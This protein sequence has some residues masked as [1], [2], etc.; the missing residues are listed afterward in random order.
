MCR[1]DFR[2]S[3]CGRLRSQ[4]PDRESDSRHSPSWFFQTLVGRISALPGVEAAS[5]GHVPF[6]PSGTTVV[7]L[8]FRGRPLA[9]VHPAAAVDAVSE[10]FQH[11]SDSAS[12]GTH[13]LRPGRRGL[14]AGG[15][16]R[17]CLRRRLLCRRRCDR[18]FVAKEMRRRKRCTRLWAWSATW[19]SA[20]SGSLHSRRCPCRPCRMD[21]RQHISIV[22]EAPG[23]DVTATVRQQLREM[24]PDVALF[25]VETMADRVSRSVRLRRF[26][27]GLLNIF[28]A[29]GLLIAARR[30]VRNTGSRGPTAAPRNRN[31]AR[32]RE[33]TPPASA[34]ALRFAACWWLGRAPAGHGARNRRGSDDE[35]LPFWNGPARHANG[36]DHAARIRRV[37]RSRFVDSD[38]ARGTDRCAG[39]SS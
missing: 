26:V 39:G 18:K 22:R 25:D 28:A 33:H 16:R 8:H 35:R 13:V 2:R 21:N 5:A 24:D 32:A 27:A 31:Q 29:M 38:G 20:R 1:S 36:C 11:P 9:P 19:Q 10:L 12:E 30:T 15:G 23:Q 37:D 14:D 17:S 34:D 7:D 3:A 6:N 4:L